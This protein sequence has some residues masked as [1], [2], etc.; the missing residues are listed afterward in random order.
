MNIPLPMFHTFPNDHP[1][2]LVFQH[3]G[4]SVVNQQIPEWFIHCVDE[5]EQ[6]CQFY[7]CNDISLG[8]FSTHF[9]RIFRIADED[10][11]AHTNIS[12]SCHGVSNSYQYLSVVVYQDMIIRRMPFC[13]LPASILLFSCYQKTLFRIPSQLI[14]HRLSCCTVV[15]GWFVIEDWRD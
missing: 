11:H 14:D 2:M 5:Q 15:V 3:H 13:R 12:S 10:T 6:S 8:D 9:S 4:N 1:A 7:F